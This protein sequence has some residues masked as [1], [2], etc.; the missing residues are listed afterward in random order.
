MNVIKV[1]TDTHTQSLNVCFDTRQCVILGSFAITTPQPS[2]NPTNQPTNT[3][4]RQNEEKVCNFVACCSPRKTHFH[5]VHFDNVAGFSAQSLSLSAYFLRSIQAAV[6]A[7]S[8]NSTASYMR[9]NAF[10]F[11]II[12]AFSNRFLSCGVSMIDIETMIFS[13][14]F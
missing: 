4:Y 5:N 10:A 14:K 1:H 9:L 6:F 2:N 8:F 13:S 12:Y 7:T 11:S 3:V